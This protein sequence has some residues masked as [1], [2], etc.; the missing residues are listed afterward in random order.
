MNSIWLLIPILLT[1]GL[2][3]LRT[4][5]EDRFLQENL[6][7]YREYANKIQSRLVPGLW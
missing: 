2:Y 4:S 7:G 3:V 5:L 6:A 1:V